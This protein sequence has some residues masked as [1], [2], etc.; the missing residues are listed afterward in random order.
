MAANTAVNCLDHPTST[1]L[2]DYPAM[3]QTA[4]SSAPIFGPLLV[5]GL[6]GCAAWPYPPT[7]Q[8]Q[9]TTAVGAPPILVVGTTG[10]PATPYQWAEHLAS[11]LQHGELVTWKGMNHV[12]YFYSPCIRAI[13]ESYLV[14]GTLPPPNTICSD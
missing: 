6:I 2:S 12:A 9:A 5:W 7:R 1:Q 11:E 10:D 14:A 8:P 4:A 13:D 3:A